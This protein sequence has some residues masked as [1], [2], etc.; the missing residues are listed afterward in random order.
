MGSSNLSRSLIYDEVRLCWVRATS[1][2]Q[3]RQQWLKRMIGQL[4]YP[5]EL[6]VVEKE[7][8]ELPHLFGKTVPHRRVDILCYGKDIHPNHSLYPLIMIEC[9]R[10]RLTNAAMDQALGYN[11]HVKAHLIAVVNLEEVRWGYYNTEGKRYPCC[12]MLPSFKELMQW[13]RL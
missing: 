12:S 13:V 6:L 1:E 5:K 2:E 3:V 8:K 7:L 11:H 10:G 4:G 9:K